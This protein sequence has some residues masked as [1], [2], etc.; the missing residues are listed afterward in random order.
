MPEQVSHK[1][2]AKNTIALYIR[3]LIS[4]CIGLYTSRVVID[5]LGVDDYGVYG[6]AGGFVAMLAFINNAMAG[7]TSRFITYEMGLGDRERIRATF[8][9]ALTVH[10]GIAVIVAVICEAVGVWVLNT[11]LNIPPDRL[12]AANVVFQLSILSAAVSIT[13]VPYT[14][15][16]IS[17]ERM[18]IYAY[19]EIANVTLKL[20]IVYFLL[21]LPGDKLII[22]AILTAI[23]SILIALAYRLY[24][25]RQFPES[26][27]RPQ[28]DKTFIR[29]IL[30]FSG[31]D[32]YGNLCVTARNQGL[33]FILN[34]FFGVAINGAASIANTL[35]ATLSGFSNNIVTAFRP[36]IIKNYAQ[37]AL[38]VFQNLITMASQLSAMMLIM[39]AIPLLI[40]TPYV[41]GL[42]LGEVP[43]WV[44]IFSRITIIYAIIT[45]IN[46]VINIGIHATGR[47]KR[48]SFLSGTIFLLNLPLV[49]IALRLGGT[50]PVAFI[51]GIAVIAV[52]LL[53]N[54]WNLKHNVPQFR[55]LRYLGKIL[56]LPLISIPACAA[57][58][59]LHL[60]MP[61]NFLR[62]ALV[63]LT[64]VLL[65]ALSTYAFTLNSSQRAQIR[66]K[67]HLSHP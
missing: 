65:I 41:F 34:I 37:Q 43:E 67:L 51:I 59:Y 52:L 58:Y 24:C 1:R 20:V 21:I 39:M 5:T 64:S 29:P 38:D 47:I 6:V 23:V 49:W 30:S 46:T 25:L 2:I 32:M 61:E 14:A 8:A 48:L 3:G 62:F 56:I 36:Q 35:N 4:V 53:I 9:N 33:T 11:R 42:W 31:W 54:I 66:A 10:I 13:Q 16:I 40:E 12:T 15:L 18:G 26:R 17:N 60:L 19:M 27:T 63:C 28:Y 55:S 7:A 57:C 44:V 22:Y 45:Q 50:P